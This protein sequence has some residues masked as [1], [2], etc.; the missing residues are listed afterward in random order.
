MDYNKLFGQGGMEE[1]NE[2]SLRMHKINEAAASI[3]EDPAVE[4]AINCSVAMAAKVFKTAAE[5]GFS[6]DQS[7]ELAHTMFKTIVTQGVR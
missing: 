4:M 5:N 6:E 2:R 1:A 7:F 3:E